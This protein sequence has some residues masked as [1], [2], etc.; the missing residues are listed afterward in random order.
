[1]PSAARPTGD[2]C[3]FA[4]CVFDFFF[5]LFVCG[6]V[7]C[8]CLFLLF[9]CFVCLFVLFCFVCF[10]CFVCLF[11]L[12]CLF[13]WLVGICL[14]VCLL[15][16]LFDCSFV[17]LFDCSFVC[18][19]VWVGLVWFGVVCSVSL[20]AFFFAC[21]FLFSSVSFLALWLNDHMDHSG[22]GKWKLQ[23]S[24]GRGKSSRGVTHRRPFWFA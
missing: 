5:F 18:L 2:G 23:P 16:C 22:P 20:L 10:V 9:V 19:L 1:M 21:L 14:F 11:C 17:G 6:V 7:F 8:V 24:S 3:L 4:R 13:V 12:L 15:A